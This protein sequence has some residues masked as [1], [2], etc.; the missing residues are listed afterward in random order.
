MCYDQGS[1]AHHCHYSRNNLERRRLR[2]GVHNAHQNKQ[3]NEGPSQ[4][5]KLPTCKATSLLQSLHEKAHDRLFIHGWRQLAI[6]AV[7]GYEKKEGQKHEACSNHPGEEVAIL[8]LNPDAWHTRGRPTRQEGVGDRTSHVDGK[9]EIQEKGC[10]F[11]LCVRISWIK[12]IGS[13]GANIGLDAAGAQGNQSK[14]PDQ[15]E[16]NAIHVG[17]GSHRTEISANRIS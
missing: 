7:A 8:D 2:K 3:R 5:C 17:Q 14:C 16:G 10:S 13:H 15:V 4:N 6:A 9:V 12:L 1:N 11:L